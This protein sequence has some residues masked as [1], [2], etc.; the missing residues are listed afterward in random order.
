M[1][2]SLRTTGRGWSCNS[3][4]CVG[5]GADAQ[6]HEHP[7][8]RHSDRGCVRPY[9]L[10]SASSTTS[11]IRPIPRRSCRL[12]DRRSISPTAY[13]GPLGH[14]FRWDL[15]GRSG[16][17]GRLGAQRRLESSGPG[18]VRGGRCGGGL[19]SGCW[20]PHRPSCCLPRPL[21]G[22]PGGAEPLPRCPEPVP[23]W[24]GIRTQVSGTGAQ[25]VKNP[26]PS[27][28]NGRPSQAGIGAQVSPESVPKLA[29]KTQR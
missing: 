17:L 18:R 16:P 24:S 8:S 10:G 21:P 25:V 7:G 6:S 3:R 13:S 2:C 29:R 9:G 11:S 23:R 14:P 27:A 22:C 15:G 20:W 4:S 1:A 19:I 28:R 12:L 5:L 26:C